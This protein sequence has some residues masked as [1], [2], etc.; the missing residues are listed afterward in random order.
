V[1]IISKGSV[2]VNNV[3]AVVSPN[4]FWAHVW[5]RKCS[6]CSLYFLEPV[7]VSANR[8]NAT[9]YVW[10]QT[11]CK[12][13]AAAHL[14]TEIRLWHSWGQRGAGPEKSRCIRGLATVECS[15][16]VGTSLFVHDNRLEVQNICLFQLMSNQRRLT[17]MVQ[18]YSSQCQGLVSSFQHKGW[19]SLWWYSAHSLL[20]VLQSVSVWGRYSYS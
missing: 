4:L 1:S 10:K 9:F 15:G 16:E 2:G 6:P 8:S 3:Y 5:D 11:I 12:K 20:L 14:P 19:W 17:M 13:Y 7:K 18:H